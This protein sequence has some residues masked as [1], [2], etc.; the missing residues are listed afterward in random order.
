MGSAVQSA[1]VAKEHQDGGPVSPQFTQPVL[2]AV[3]IGQ[4]DRFQTIEIHER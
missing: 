1:E 3:G 2:F 4:G